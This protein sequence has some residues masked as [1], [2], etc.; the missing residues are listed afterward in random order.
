MQGLPAEI[1]P[2]LAEFHPNSACSDEAIAEVER[3]LGCSFPYEY[4][5]FLRYSN[6]GE[7]HVGKESY[8]ILDSVEKLVEYNQA[9]NLAES[10]PGLVLFGSDGGGTYFAFDMADPNIRVMAFDPVSASPEDQWFVGRDFWDFLKRLDQFVS[11]I[12]WNNL[13]K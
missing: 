3:N 4:K 9:Q 11:G 7:G 1:V 10:R 6:G 12:D 8:L 2:L 5:Q 13:G